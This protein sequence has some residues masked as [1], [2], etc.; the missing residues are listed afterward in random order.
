M[1]HG[2]LVPKAFLIVIHQRMEGIFQDMLRLLGIITRVTVVVVVLQKTEWRR[3][4]KG[5]LA[6]MQRDQ[7]GEEMTP[8]KPRQVLPVISIVRLGEPVY[9]KGPHNLRRGSPF[10]PPQ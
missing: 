10:F 7:K 2:R 9:Q 3:R 8:V 4:R 1:D 6:T 5:S